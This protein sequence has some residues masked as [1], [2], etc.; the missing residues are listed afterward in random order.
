MLNRIIDASVR[1]RWLVVCRLVVVVIQ[2]DFVHVV[3]SVARSLVVV[4]VAPE[5]HLLLDD[6]AR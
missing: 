2:W 1:F 3:P 6:E 4:D 5:I